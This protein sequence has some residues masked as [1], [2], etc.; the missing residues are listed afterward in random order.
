M[1][2]ARHSS[3]CNMRQGGLAESD[4]SCFV[5]DTTVCKRLRELYINRGPC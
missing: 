1:K 4:L 5:D 2:A 3:D